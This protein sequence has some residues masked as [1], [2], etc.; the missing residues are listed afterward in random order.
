MLNQLSVVICTKNEERNIERCLNSVNDIADEIIVVDSFST[1][2]TAQICQK[3]PK[4]K[5]FSMTWEGFAKTKNKANQLAQNPHILSLD[6]DEEL[7]SE[8]QKEIQ[9]LKK[10]GFQGV[11]RL[12]RI[13]NYAGSWVRHSGWFPDKKIRIFPKMGSHWVGDHVHE[14]LEYNKDLKIIDCQGLLN[15]YS[16]N[17]VQDHVKKVRQYSSLGA[18]KVALKKPMVVIAISMVF[19][20]FFRFLRHYIFKLGFLDGVPGVLIAALSS[21]SVFLKYRGALKIK[22]KASSNI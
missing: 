2:R 1:D 10:S 4:V 17:S 22:L 12:N 5:F 7:T 15:H 21:Y 13:T 16:V 20:P 6:A 3:F 9:A 19:N 11:Y 18:E 8:L 14:I